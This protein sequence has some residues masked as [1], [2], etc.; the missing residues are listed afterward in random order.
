MKNCGVCGVEMVQ[1]RSEGA[2]YFARKKY[3]SFACRNKSYK[4]KT[5]DESHP[6]WKGESASYWAKHAWVYLRLGKANS[7]SNEGCKYPRRTPQGKILT[8]PK[9]F[10]WANISGNYI[11]ELS[12]WMQ[13]CCSCHKNYDLSRK[14]V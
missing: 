14:T 12:D 8:A 11:R 1:K 5:T 13:L 3:C 7:C 2:P 6:N 10:E 4:G 9:R